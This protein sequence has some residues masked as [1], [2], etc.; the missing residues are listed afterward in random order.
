MFA[1]ATSPRNS[2]STD[3]VSA[4]ANTSGS[5]STAMVVPPTTARHLALGKQ[6]E[7]LAA[8]H[9]SELGFV[10]LSRNWRCR[11]GELDL[12]VTD[13]Q[14]IV[15]CEVKTRSG[16]R[17]GDPA[18]AVTKD[19]RTRIKRVTGEWLRTFHVGWCRI[20][21]DVIAVYVP[22]GE[23]VRLRHIVGAF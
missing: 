22:P 5:D 8:R 17:F 2:G 16:S 12:V 3:D 9:L 7:Y 11:E 6:G 23:D 18:E 4:L 19:K 20:R 1:L 21:F 13:G 10:L 14:T 15:I